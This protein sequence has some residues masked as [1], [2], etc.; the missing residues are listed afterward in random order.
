MLATLLASEGEAVSVDALA[1]SLWG[2]DQPRSAVRTLHAYVARLRKAL[3]VNGEGPDLLVTRGRSYQLLLPPDAVDADRFVAAAALGRSLSER[4]DPGGSLAACDRALAE[5]TGSAYAGHEDIDRCAVA[6]RVLDEVRRGAVEDRFEALL[7]LGQ[8]GEMVA[9]L[10]SAV[11]EE[12]LR[13]RRWGQLMLA[14]YRSGRQAEALRAFQRAR[15]A[16][17][18]SLGVEPG[19]ELCEL[20]AAILAQDEARLRSEVGRDD[21]VVALPLALDAAGSAFVGRGHELDVL[22]DTWRQLASGRGAYVAVV[23]PEGIGKTRVVSELAAQAHQ[24][25]AI[26]CFARCDR[27]H[28]SARRRLRPGLPVGR[29]LPDAGA[30]GRSDRRVAGGH[31]RPSPDCVGGDGAGAAGA[32]R[33]PRSRARGARGG[34][35]RRRLDQHDGGPRRRAVPHGARGDSSSHR[36]RAAARGARTRA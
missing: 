33:P 26:I 30:G 31:D 5:W 23:G 7:A 9:E 3:S 8:T 22:R 32:R 15:E 10:E 13:E 24:D 29:Q 2:D 11:G 1:E 19:P 16:L 20:E 28:R 6:A 18:D 21:P 25:G 12:P 27:D 14:L 4:C 34:R 36:H 35:R 17:V